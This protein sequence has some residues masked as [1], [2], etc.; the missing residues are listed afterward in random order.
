V[1]SDSS[2][3]DANLKER[4]PDEAVVYSVSVGEFDNDTNE[5]EPELAVANEVHASDQAGVWK[6]SVEA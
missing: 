5:R 3:M 4:D 2:H 1:Y 6:T